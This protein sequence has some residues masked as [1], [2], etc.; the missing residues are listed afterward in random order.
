MYKSRNLIFASIATGIT[1]LILGLCGGLNV[2]T[3]V[4]TLVFWYGPTLFSNNFNNR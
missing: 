4:V 1:L 3:A 2:I